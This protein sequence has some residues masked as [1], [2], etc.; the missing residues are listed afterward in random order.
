MGN[1]VTLSISFLGGIGTVT[2][3]RFLLDRHGRRILVGCGLFQNLKQ[4][5]LRY[6]A[7]FPVDPASVD[8]APLTLAHL[9]H[10]GYLP[11]LVRDGFRDRA[12]ASQAT[13]DL[14]EILLKVS[15]FLQGKDAEYANKHGFPKHKPAAPLYTLKDAEAALRHLQ[16]VPFH[17]RHS[18]PDGPEILLRRAGHTSDQLRERG[19]E[20]PILVAVHALFSEETYRNLREKAAAVVSANPVV[21]P[22]NAINLSAALADTV[23]EAMSGGISVTSNKEENLK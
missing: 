8:A 6:G 10:S 17:E 12:H 18:L 11:A 9:D 19:L 14:C 5:R 3:S 20:R 23:S 4:F 16:A 15:G 13:I 7:K 1:S 21:H 2:G 22:S